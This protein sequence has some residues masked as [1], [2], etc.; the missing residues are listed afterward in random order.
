MRAFVA[1]VDRGSLA[2]AARG[3]GYSPAT[4]TR[5]IAMLE[6]RL[7]VRLLHRS[8]RALHLTPFG[9]MYL[10]TCRDIL[11]VLDAAESGAKAEQ[12]K[13]RG[14]LTITAPLMFGRLHVRSVVDAFLDANPEVRARL[15]L[16]DRVA[17]VVEEGIDLAVRVAHLSDSS[18]TATQ[19]GDVRRVLCAAPSYI[20]RRGMPRTPADLR[21][22]ACIMERDGAETELWRFA[23]PQRRSLLPIAVR[24]RLMV[25]SAAAAVDSAIGGH[26]ITRVMSYQASAAVAAGKLVVLLPQNEPPP[27]PVHIVL[28]STHMKTQKQRA[29]V[30]FAAP[31]LRQALLD[32]AAEISRGQRPARVSRS[33]GERAA[34]SAR[35]T[36][37]RRKE[38]SP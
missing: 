9:E 25:N 32:A 14:L 30:S 20:A 35:Q 33:S 31:L 13:P 21:E 34:L 37:S 10:A 4:M 1:S 3:L 16:L 11:G 18:L 22:H 26:G 36:K 38:P 2:S 12:E 27:I 17:N 23:N 6:K 8:T 24:P 29:F 7:E 19:V 15:I 5:A 28:P